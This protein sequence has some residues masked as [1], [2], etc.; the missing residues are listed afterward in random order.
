MR[1]ILFR[2]RV[3]N[4]YDERIGKW[5]FGHLVVRPDHEDGPDKYFICESGYR[6]IRCLNKMPCTY[7][8]DPDT[9][10]QYTGLINKYGEWIFEG[11]I[12]KAKIEDVRSNH[13]GFEW[14]KMQVD[15]ME[16]GFC[17]IDAVGRKFAMLGA[18]APSVTF[19][20]IGNIH[21]NPELIAEVEG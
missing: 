9:V 15:F 21:D 12:I 13:A 19:E 5:I 10:G 18:F 3:I 20:V 16:G 14:P 4:T 1:E 6:F 2:G 7:E 8:V 17:L 11:D